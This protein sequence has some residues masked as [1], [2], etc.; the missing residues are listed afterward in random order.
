MKSLN[1]ILVFI[2]FFA[3]LT[4]SCK[5]ITL[6]NDQFPND[7]FIADGEYAGEYWPTVSWRTCSPDEVGM[8]RELLKR[9]N[10]EI[11]ILQRLNVD[12][13][14][15]I[16]IKN[17]YIIAEQYYSDYTVDSLHSIYSCT[18]SI[19]SALLGI[20]IQEGH[21]QSVDTKMVDHFSEYNIE[22]LTEEKQNI[23]IEHLLTM[24]AGL[25]WYE[26]E[27][28]YGDERNSFYQW[29]RSADRVQYVLD[30][31][32]IN[33]PGTD[34]NYNTGISHLLSAI[35]QK[36]TGIRTDLYAEDRLFNYLGI[37]QYDWFIEPN[38]IPTGGHGM[39]LRPRDLARFGYLYL[40]NGKWENEQIIP[41]NWVKTA[42]DSHIK[43]KY[44]TDYYY[45]Y[46][47]WVKPNEY[48]CAVG[49]GGQWMFIAPDHNLVAVF[50][51]N[52]NEEEYLQFTTPER[53]FQ[54]F[55]L[56]AV[57]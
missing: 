28:P 23:T 10:E 40:K 31:P 11:L 7:G 55:I 13:H 26:L 43:R 3:L 17:G 25:E 44:L 50:N 49:F 24:S 48:Y 51:N 8:D 20:V 15:V 42:S 37:E 34:Y 5:K 47:W 2:L 18:K 6:D 27:Y 4:S 1:T 46:Q 33:P 53:L 38:G 35:I 19:T 54:N 12:V 14:S 45:G 36:T 41:E 22:N 32:V 30:L 52:F 57:L 16:I 29:V 39:K 56:P 9:V 21:V